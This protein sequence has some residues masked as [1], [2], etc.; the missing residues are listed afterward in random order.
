MRRRRRRLDGHALALGCA[1]VL[2]LGSCGGGKKGGDAG[3][4]DCD[5][6]C[7]DD[8]VCYEDECCEPRTCASAGSACGELDD[9]CG[10][11]VEC[12]CSSPETCGGGGEAGV[13]GCE[14]T[15]CTAEGAE[16]G[17]IPDGCGG[18][19]GC[20]TC[21]DP[22][23]PFCQDDNTCSDEECV[24]DSCA[25]RGAECGMAAIG[26]GM[27]GDC[28]PCP[29]GEMCEDNECVPCEGEG[30]EMPPTT[31]TDATFRI[32]CPER[33]CADATGCSPS[34]TCEYTAVDC[35]G[36]PGECPRRECT[37]TRSTDPD[38]T[39]HWDNACVVVDGAPC[40]DGGTCVGARCVVPI[41]TL[42]GTLS[43]G[44]TDGTMGDVTL[45]GSVGFYRPTL[46]RRCMGD[47]CLSGGISP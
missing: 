40:G 27:V 10:G 45:H 29:E 43:V 37:G 18:E 28:G 15:T 33:E 11:T 35:G 13:C 32:D 3:P 1:V 23:R 9:F 20:G 4:S 44:A 31:C 5:P 12:G 22:A 26:C 17:Q 39:V 7:A 46:G 24:P 14:P 8:E 47:V 25:D 21:D 6:P 36:T 2:L 42:S 34:G 30:C 41:D 16:C 38:G 19:R